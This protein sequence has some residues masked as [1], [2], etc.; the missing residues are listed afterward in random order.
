MN[1]KPIEWR[2]TVAQQGDACW[3]WHLQIPDEDAVPH[4]LEA[5]HEARQPAQG[6]KAD[7]VTKRILQLGTRLHA[8]F[9]CK[10][11]TLGH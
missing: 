7:S 1:R 5:G 4:D 6:G 2:H 9:A 3:G 11:C 8:S 10:H